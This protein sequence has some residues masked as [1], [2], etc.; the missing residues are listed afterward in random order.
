MERIPNKIMED[1]I[2]F[3]LTN[4]KDEYVARKWNSIILLILS[5]NYHVQRHT[6][7]TRGLQMS[8][9]CLVAVSDQVWQIQS[10]SEEEECLYIIKHI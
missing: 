9:D 5:P 7:H 10:S 4:E 3:L 2:R 6:V 8:D 1:L